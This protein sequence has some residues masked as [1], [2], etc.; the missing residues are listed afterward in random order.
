MTHST[1]TEVIEIT[2]CVRFDCDTTVDY[3]PTTTY[4]AR[5]LSFDAISREQ[6]MNMTI[7]RRSRVVYSR[8]AVE[9]N[10]NCNSITSV[11][12]ECVVVSSYRRRIVVES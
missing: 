2:I 1:T 3:D 12:V 5:L 8:I 9:S 10:A 4:H 7:F 6:K 11:V